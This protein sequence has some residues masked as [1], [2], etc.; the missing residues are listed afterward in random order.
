MKHFRDKFRHHSNQ[1]GF[2]LMEVLMGIAIFAIGMLA[3][4]SL[5]GALTRSTAEAKVRT[6]AVNIA[7]KIIEE[8]R[9]FALVSGGTFSFADIVD[10]SIDSPII[11][12]STMTRDPASVDLVGVT[13]TVTQDVTDYY[14][15]L[16]LDVD[17]DTNAFTTTA[18]TGAITADYK[19]VLVTVA[20]DDDRSFV[21]DESRSTTN[22]DVDPALNFGG[23]FIQ[24]SATIS[25]IS[26]TTA[27]KVTEEEDGDII[28]PP[29]AYAPGLNP[30]IVALDLGGNK[31]KETL[32][33]EPK[34]FRDNLETRF[35]VI[36]YAQNDGNFFLRR[37]EF[38]AVSC[39]CTLRAANASFP[40]FR[41]AIWA[42]DEYIESD[43]VTKAYG[44]AISNVAQSPLCDTCCRDH[45]DGGG[46]G[47]EPD[48]GIILYDPSRLV[49]EY[50]SDGGDHKHYSRASGGSAVLPVA[51]AGDDYVEACRFI[52]V[53][54]FFRLAQ[55]FRLE[56]I[57]SF[58]EDFLITSGEVTDYSN[59]VTGE[60]YNKDI[61]SRNYTSSAS[62]Y[63]NAAIGI[64][65]GYH[66]DASPPMVVPPDRTPLEETPIPAGDLTF[67]YTNL[68]TST[69]ATFQ[70]LRSRSIYI[71][72]LSLDLRNVITC[73]E[74]AADEAAAM[75]CESGDVKLDQSG[76][77]NVLE[78]IPFFELQTTFLSDWAKNDSGDVGFSVTNEPVETNNTHTRGRATKL[79]DL[80]DDV[81]TAIANRG[82]S[83]LTATDP[84]NNNTGYLLS[85]QGEIRVIVSAGNPET[86]S[87]RTITGT[88]RSDVGGLKASNVSIT[89]SDAI[90]NY[91][92]AS[93]VFTCFIPDS[94]ISEK[95][96][97]GNFQKPPNTIFI[98]SSHQY[99]FAGG[100][101]G[102]LEVKN[103]N[104]TGT[105]T[106]D[107]DL[108]RALTEP[109]DPATQYVIWLDDEACPTGGG[110]GT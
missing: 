106:K 94:A 10:V 72:Y 19:T 25:S 73:I 62:P 70:Q 39:E 33:P 88:I 77:V 69:G 1:R 54:G 29:I 36:T 14:Y 57:N 18:P 99:N 108:T 49:G 92:S 53:D 41:P 110:I 7:E 83:G 50:V 102:E 16:T 56:G 80:G 65:N 17:P 5:Q 51:S 86:P 67:D 27:L 64:G 93:G 37:E 58:P 71:D 68:P 105:Q 87:G 48:P 91:V 35:D 44:E 55:D 2:S 98:C 81:V 61:A 34:V 90:C 96:I 76:S 9:G 107:I 82:V 74:E 75:E 24:L 97:I 38:V 21:I 95:M 101:P 52:R 79:T 40:G 15:D 11:F 20:W 22:N 26:A 28:A 3:L 32:T 66:A 60:V 30:D 6:T 63:V 78:L 13:Y 23:G 100:S 45:H 59:F 8:Q 89:A 43:P 4:A 84:I 103:N 104:D 31:L 85:G 12:D 47:S 42:G 46:S 109:V